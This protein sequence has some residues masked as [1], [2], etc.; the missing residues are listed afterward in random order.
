[1]LTGLPPF[2][3][4]DVQE[5]YRRIM[6]DKLKFPPTMS[7]PAR[8][9]IEGLLQR[10]PAERLK[11]PSKIKEHVF[12]SGIDWDAIYNKKVKAPF[13]PQVKSDLDVTNVDQ[14]FLSEAPAISPSTRNEIDKSDQTNFVG[15]TYVNESNYL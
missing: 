9:L 8:L 5:M 6:T 12:F 13:L 15:F 1:M 3:S 7:E 14:M 2:Y 10:D 4:Q 11:D